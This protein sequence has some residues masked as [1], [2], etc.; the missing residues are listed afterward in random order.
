MDAIHTKIQKNI[1]FG[2][3]KIL[4]PSHPFLFLDSIISSKD[5]NLFYVI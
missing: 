1:F 4:F 5:L 3:R 2:D